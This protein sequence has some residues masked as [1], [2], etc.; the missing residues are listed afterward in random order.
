MKVSP[1]LYA[2]K[3]HMASKLCSMLATLAREW[4][5][6]PLELMD[7]AFSGHDFEAFLQHLKQPGVICEHGMKTVCH[8]MWHG[9]DRCI[10]HA[11]DPSEGWACQIDYNP[12]RF[13]R[14]SIFLITTMRGEQL[15]CSS[16]RSIL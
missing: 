12:E 3:G 11:V 6:Q 16:C 14:C 4:K 5:Q 15:R 13:V 1:S 10:C 8:E 9:F 7:T 2:R